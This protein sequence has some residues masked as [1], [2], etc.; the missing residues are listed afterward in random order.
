[1]KKYS[2]LYIRQNLNTFS[3]IKLESV[4]SCKKILECKRQYILLTQTIMP[5]QGLEPKP[6]HKFKI[7]TYSEYVEYPI[8]TKNI[9]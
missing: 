4:A 9:L 5:K 6:M 7:Y 8:K 1:M 2:M 3:T